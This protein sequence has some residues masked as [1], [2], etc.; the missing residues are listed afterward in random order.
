MIADLTNATHFYMMRVDPGDADVSPLNERDPPPPAP[1]CRPSRTCKVV[2]AV[3]GLFFLFALAYS[4]NTAGSRVYLMFGG[5]APCDGDYSAEFLQRACFAPRTA[6]HLL[7]SPDFVQQKRAFIVSAIYDGG[8]ADGREALF[9]APVADSSGSYVYKFVPAIAGWMDLVRVAQHLRATTPEAMALLE[10]ENRWERVATLPVLKRERSGAMWIDASEL[11]FTMGLFVTDERDIRV[12]S[13]V[14]FP[15]NVV[16]RVSTPTDDLEIGLV[17]L[18]RVPAMAREAD[19]RVGYFT[20]ALLVVDRDPPVTRIIHRMVRRAAHVFH[21]DPSVPRQWREAVRA[22]VE[23]WN[24]AFAA[25][26]WADP[27]MRAVMPDDADWP[28]DYD[29]G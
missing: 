21:V 24:P 29:A 9:H 20:T 12:E 28:A 6:L 27:P 10:R 7:V 4:A 26:G 11:L 13:T 8:V 22:G 2:G 3:C 25:A 19:A 18:P 1:R 14:V 5:F 16:I 15:R 17:A 23:G